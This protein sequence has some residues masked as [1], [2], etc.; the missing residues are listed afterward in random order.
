MAYGPTVLEPSAVIAPPNAPT[1]AA[2]DPAVT[3]AARTANAMTF[4]F[5]FLPLFRFAFCRGQSPRAPSPDGLKRREALVAGWLKRLL[6]WV[7]V[8]WKP[9]SATRR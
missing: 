1:R 2:A 5:M 3:A 7:A 4:F 6:Q 9:L 8:R